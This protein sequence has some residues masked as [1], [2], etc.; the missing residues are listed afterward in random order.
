MTAVLDDVCGHTAFASTGKGPWTGATVKVTLAYLFIRDRGDS[1]C[2]DSDSF[3]LIH[4]TGEL[5]S[6]ETYSYRC[7]A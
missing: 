4:V 2:G 7:S 5:Q 1:A 6:E 3:S